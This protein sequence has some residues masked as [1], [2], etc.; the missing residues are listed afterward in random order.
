MDGKK[1]PLNEGMVSVKKYQKTFHGE[2][3]IPSIIKFFFAFTIYEK[4]C[5]TIYEEVDGKEDTLN[6][7]IVSMKKYQKTFHVEEI[8]PSIIEFVRMMK[9][10]L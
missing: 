3:I 7:V 5:E 2:E 6:K 9:E 10:R 8:I 4:E 1:V